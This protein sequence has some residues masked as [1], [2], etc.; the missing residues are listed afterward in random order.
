MKACMR[1]SAALSV[2]AGLML[3][4]VGPYTLITTP[5][6]WVGCLFVV[7]LCWFASRDTAEAAC[8]A[9]PVNRGGYLHEAALYDRHRL[10]EEDICM[11]QHCMAVTG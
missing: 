11:R 10:T 5:L 1:H 7:M 3:A 6:M 2:R 8:M 9:S 4:M